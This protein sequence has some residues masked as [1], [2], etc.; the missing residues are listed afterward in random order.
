MRLPLFI[1]L[2]YSGTRASNQLVAFLSRVSMVGLIVGVGLLLAVLSIMNGFDRELRE[3]ILG[4]VP[5]AAIYGREPIE[6]W[7]SLQSKIEQEPRVNA[8]APF[9][10]V[11]GLAAYQKLAEPV[12]LFG[13][14]P[15]QEARVSRIADFLSASTLEAISSSPS[16]IVLGQSIAQKLQLTVGDELMLLSPDANATGAPKLEYFELIEVLST[17]TELDNT[18]ALTDIHSAAQLTAN[19]QAV[20]GLRLKLEDLFTARTTVWD[21]LMQLGVGYYGSSW[22]NTHGNLYHAI[23]LSKTLVALLMSLIVAIA[24]FNV[25]STL[26]MVVIEKQADIAILRTYGASTFDITKIFIVQGSAIGFIG[27]SIGVAFGVVLALVV[28][29]LVQWI[30]SLLGTQ[31]L[32]S[33]VYPLTYLPTEI[34][35]N[36]ILLVGGVS[37]LMSFLA[38]LYPAWR[39]SKIMPAEVLR[40]E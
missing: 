15:Q 9:V 11:N 38:T 32:Q 33:D 30:E 18:L 19:A 22:M 25:V 5:Q 12:V 6:D 28:E 27:I 14:N 8:A 24:A 3:R 26:I 35:L 31:F 29:K 1:G 17:N 7:Q 34:M 37:F 10:Q 40:Y 2:R 39:A 4:L 21:V 20:S 16:K 36:D 23:H 13:I